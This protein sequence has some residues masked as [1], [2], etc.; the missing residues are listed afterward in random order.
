MCCSLLEMS[1]D[2]LI[3]PSLIILFSK[4]SRKWRKNWGVRECGVGGSGL[5]TS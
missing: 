4:C 2:H 3:F 1:S 5:R